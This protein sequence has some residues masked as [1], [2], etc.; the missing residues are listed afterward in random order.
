MEGEEG[1]RGRGEE[2]L[3]EEQAK[4]PRVRVWRW[5]EGWRLA[6]TTSANLAS[7]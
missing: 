6:E 2:G 1:G 3:V 4:R 7:R 5:N